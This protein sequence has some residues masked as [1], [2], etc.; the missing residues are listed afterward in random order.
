LL[1]VKAVKLNDGSVVPADIV[2]VGV[3]A[4]PLVGLLNGQVVEDKGGF[5]VSFN[6]LDNLP[7]IQAEFLQTCMEI[8]VEILE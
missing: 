8:P 6:F 3:G 5:K 4:K 2:V 1:Q 7:S